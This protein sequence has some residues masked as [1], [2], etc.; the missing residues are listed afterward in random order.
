MVVHQDIVLTFFCFIVQDLRSNA[1]L[2]YFWY[3]EAEL[4]N[5]SGNTQESV[6]ALHI[7]S[8]LGNGATYSPFECKPSSLQLLRAHQG[9]REKMKSVR[10]A[11]VRGVI[12]DQ[13]LALTCSAALF[14]E[15]T[16]GWAAGVEVLDE[17]FAMVLPGY[18]VFSC[19]SLLHFHSPINFIIVLGQAEN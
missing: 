4:A 12:D 6:R 10:S 2:L 8:C 5:S 3:A 13:S 19:F 17:A 15:L 1:P 11:W 14:E 18:E 16:T 9:F 7:L